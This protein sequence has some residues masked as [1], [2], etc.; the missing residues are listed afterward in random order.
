M[1]RDTCLSGYS[2]L[3]EI[4]PDCPVQRLD[5][6]RENVFLDGA[7]I[8]YLAG[9]G[10]LRARVRNRFF[11]IFFSKLVILLFYFGLPPPCPCPSEMFFHCVDTP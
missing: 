7:I 4:L 3:Y 5:H 1:A 8:L 2:K 11:C 6:H 10:L 9:E